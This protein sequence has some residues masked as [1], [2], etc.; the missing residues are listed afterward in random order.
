M[1]SKEKILN[2]AA[3]NNHQKTHFRHKD[4]NLGGLIRYKVMVVFGTINLPVSILQL[5]QDNH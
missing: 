2:I 3:S 4:P 5:L 1:M